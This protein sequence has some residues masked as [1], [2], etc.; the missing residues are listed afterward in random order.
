MLFTILLG[1][2]FIVVSFKS[3]IECYMIYDGVMTEAVVE[4]T[5]QKKSRNK[6]GQRY[7]IVNYIYEVDESM[8]HGEQIVHRHMSQGEKLKIYYDKNNPQQNGI[9]ELNMYSM[10]AGIIFSVAGI[11]FLIRKK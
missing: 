6:N 10:L 4:N 2:V 11:V 9:L 1:V 3:N 5:I 8:Y 7:Y